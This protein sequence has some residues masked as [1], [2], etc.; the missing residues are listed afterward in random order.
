MMDMQWGMSWEMWMEQWKDG[1]VV[2]HS[3]LAKAAMMVC[4]QAVCLA[5]R[6]DTPT[7]VNTVG[8]WAGSLGETM[9]GETVWMKVIWWVVLMADS[10]DGLRD[11]QLGGQ[12]AVLWV[13]SK[14]A[15][16]AGPMEAPMDASMVDMKVDETAVELVDLTVCAL[17][18]PLVVVWGI[19]RVGAMADSMVATWEVPTVLMLEHLMV[20]LRAAARVWCLARMM[21]G[22]TECFAVAWKATTRDCR[23]G[24]WK[25]VL[26]AGWWEVPLAVTKELGMGFLWAQRLAAQLVVTLVGLVTWLG[27]R[28]ARSGWKL[29]ATKVAWD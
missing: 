27:V 24:I 10:L 15:T 12:M 26:S 23:L 21:V 28:L 7:D 13:G 9:V 3:A 20:V 17:D 14:V 18:S 5:S 19:P 1:H 11:A 6:K 16:K 29:V 8:A 2:E 22:K 4:R 25:V